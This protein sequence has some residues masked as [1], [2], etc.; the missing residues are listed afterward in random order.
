MDRT[1]GSG[2]F[3][4]ILGISENWHNYSGWLVEQR[5]EDIIKNEVLAL[6]VLKNLL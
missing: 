4:K 3:L 6:E 2:T 1:I 5:L